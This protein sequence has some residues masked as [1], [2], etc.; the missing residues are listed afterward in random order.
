MPFIGDTIESVRAQTCANWELVICDNMSKDGTVDCVRRLLEEKPDPRIRLIT[1]QELLPM[2]QNWNRSLAYARGE[3][4]K[5][6]PS[7]DLL[8]PDC[9]EVQQRI[10]QENPDAGFTTSGKQVIDAAGRVLFARHPLA[11]GKYDWPGLGP[12]SIRAVSNLL[13]EPGAILFRKELLATCGEYNVHYKYFVDVELLLRFLKVAKACVWGTPLYQFRIHGNSA[14][15]SSRQAALNEYQRLLDR[16]E[17]ELGFPKGSLL[18][19]YLGLK[20]R[21]VVTLRDL[22][23]RIYNR[24]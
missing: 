3:L 21:L 24:A 2:A 23:F 7:D 4:I 12:R 22:V 10:L 19:R 1:H 5:V 17:L 18:R 14:S 13:G 6:L 8:F 16:Y 11:Q 15:A 9:L 20:S